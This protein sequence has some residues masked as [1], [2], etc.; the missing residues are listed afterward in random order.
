[1][2]DMDKMQAEAAER[3]KEMY[4]RRSQ[5]QYVKNGFTNGYSG[6][7]RINQT[8]PIEKKPI[9]QEKNLHQVTDRN[10]E[11]LENNNE[12]IKQEVFSLENTANS[13]GNTDILDTLLADKEKALIILL[14]A[15][16]SEEKSSPSL[17]LALMYLII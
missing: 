4:S 15:L 8:T 10:N 17:L 7:A 1:M 16:L 14:I 5:P 2:S 11:P 12:E 6:T 9:Q 13:T 3:A